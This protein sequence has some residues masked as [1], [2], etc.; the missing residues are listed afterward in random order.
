MIY[1]PSRQANAEMTENPDL[2]ALVTLLLA[3]AGISP[4]DSEI[5][6]LTKQYA[7]LK[8]TI[9]A[10]YAIPECRYEVPALRF[11]AAAPFADWS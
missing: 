2:R 5:D 9:D 6:A 3:R 11:D 8:K 10:L 4:S 1:P 7:E